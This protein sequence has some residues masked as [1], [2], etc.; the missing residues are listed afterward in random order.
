MKNYLFIILLFFFGGCN[1]DCNTTYKKTMLFSQFNMLIPTELVET[2][3]CRLNG[4]TDCIHF[5]DVSEILDLKVEHFKNKN[6]NYEDR[7]NQAKSVTIE[8]IEKMSRKVIFKKTLEEENRFVIEYTF[9]VDNI[10]LFLGIK[11]IIF[12]EEHVI[13]VKFEQWA[14]GTKS[15]ECLNKEFMKVFNSYQL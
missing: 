10:G 3:G 8:M 12:D 13:I 2:S 14:E 15:R 1:D 4:S 7:I 9:P 11:G 6:I 5:T